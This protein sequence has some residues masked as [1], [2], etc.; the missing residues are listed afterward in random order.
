MAA[1]VQQFDARRDAT[2]K[3]Q[4]QLDE[5]AAQI[6]NQIEGL[7]F[8]LAA[9]REQVEL[10][11]QELEAQETLMAQGLTQLTRVLALRRELA[12]LKGTQGATEAS[13][14]ENRARIVEIDLEK[15][16]LETTQ[17]EEAIAELREIEFREIELRARRHALG[18]DIARLDVRAPVA[19]IVYGSTADTLRGVVRA[20]EPILYIVPQD[21]NLIARAQVDA[22]KIDQV[23]VGQAATLHF[24]AFD[25]RTTPVVLGKV[26]RVSADIFTDERTGHRY[27][28]A[29]VA[30]DATVLAELEG[31]RLVPGMPVETFIATDDR[32]ALGYFVKP[33]TDY[34]NRAFRER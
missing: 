24:S 31:R 22:A 33:M 7:E 8:Q 11:A 2:R 14:A 32:T 19:G 6:G 28:R 1:Q 9:V 34:F 17:R 5:R 16:K 21:G 3:E 30:L 18:E 26:T 4:G 10:V 29:D 23:H 12:Q 25:S 13:V 27:Y 15:L 20:A